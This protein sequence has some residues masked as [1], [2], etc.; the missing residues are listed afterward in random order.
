MDRVGNVTSDG[1]DGERGQ[2]APGGHK[3]DQAFCRASD[4]EHELSGVFAEA[5]GEVVAICLICSS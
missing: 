3:V 4:T 1:A 2:A 5:A